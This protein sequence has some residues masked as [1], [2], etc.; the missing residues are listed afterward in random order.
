MKQ[1]F[2][3][4]MAITLLAYCTNDGGPDAPQ[5]IQNLELRTSNPDF[6][7]FNI[8]FPEGTEFE[9]TESELKFTL[10]NTHYIVGVDSDGNVY[11][12]TGGGSGGV[13]CTCTIGSGCDPIKFKGEYGCLMK[14]GCS[15]C[16]KSV[17]SITGVHDELSEIVILDSDEIS[18]V[19]KFD[20]LDGNY[21]LPSSF[22]GLPEIQEVVSEINSNFDDSASY[23]DT[24]IV[25][26]NAFG[27]ILP[28]EIPS[29]GDNTSIYLRSNG[30]G[31]GGEVC[32]CLVDGEC[33]KQSKLGVV[34]CNSDKCTSC[35]MS[36]LVSNHDETF[37]FTETNGLISIQ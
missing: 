19:D 2:L 37:Q 36:G 32:T 7:S 10:P 3:F 34:R 29:E 21:L 27:Y 33:P 12:S 31:D 28:L 1:L 11:S 6:T 26:V 16:I 17:S 30:G 4:L 5:E 18:S 20:E 15:A 22:F 25:F 9:Y 35:Q 14:D 23:E 8:P 24:K 13:T